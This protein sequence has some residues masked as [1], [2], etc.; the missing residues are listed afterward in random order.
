VLNAVRLWIQLSALLV[1][2]GWLL[3]AIHQLNRTGYGVFFGLTAFGYFLWWQRAKSL[4]IKKP[5][6]F[7]HKLRHRCRRKL[8][9]LF[10]VM[11]LLIL[12]AGALYAPSNGSSTAY[13]IPRVMHWLTAEQWHWI[14]T[15]DV[16]INIAGCGYEWLS[17][18]LI[19]LTNNDRLLYLPNWISFVLLPGL[20][21]SVFTRLGVR[22]RVAWWWM[23]L[24]PSG[25]CFIMQ[26]GSTIND[27][28]AT[29]YALAALDFALRA[30]KS[31]E[32]GDVWLA[33]LAAALSTGVKQTGILLALPGLIALCPMIKLFF[34]RPIA[35]VGVIAVCVPI[36]VLVS[37][38]PMMYFNSQHG[39]N[40]SGVTDKSWN[41]AVLPSPFWGVVGNVFCL[42]LQNFK[43][44]VFPFVQSWNAARHHFLQTP[45]GSHFTGFEDFGRISFGVAESTAALGAGI[46]LLMLVSILALP[47]YWR[48]AEKLGPAKN[49]SSLLWILRWTPWLLLLAFM[50]K[51]GT[52]E[53]GRQVA[54]YY[55]LLFPLLLIPRGHAVLVQR[56]W[57]RLAALLVMAVGVALVVVS[58]DRP[59]FPAQT[60]IGW[61]KA[62]HPNS[63][64]VANI[65]LTYAETPAFEEERLFFRNNLPPDS[66]VLGYAAIS[67][68]AE[69]L[70]W[71]PF[72]QRR[73]EIVLPD[74]TPEQL[75]AAG[76]EY[77]VVTEEKF[78]Q[79]NHDTIE[80]WV[81]RNHGKSVWQK[82]FVEN[83][84][85]PPEIYYLVRLQNP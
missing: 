19:L 22:S 3:S 6:H 55:I 67:R 33:L 29:A 32:A 31:G 13:R 68:E 64:L 10:V 34:R 82:S 26:A 57:W 60:V 47:S 78:L 40:W 66:T 25:W 73:V 42:S 8:P 81:G 74:D 69:S 18:P 59:L 49:T 54:S 27:A 62:Q 53:N 12:L 43:P 5:A 70:L 4:P 80:Q 85:D 51:V 30:R 2:A 11:A 23:W 76:I 17:A 15:A 58:R 52:F 75:R 14:R 72:G 39:G 56:R 1:S 7:F 45:F 9:L 77:V 48:A 84:Y 50:A 41:T 38:A 24:L 35:S 44:P 46:S 71:L 63:K 28:F 79:K 21:F 61:L 16:R 20:V 65:A 37:A 36:C 83:P